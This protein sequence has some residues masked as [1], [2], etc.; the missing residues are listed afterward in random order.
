MH[1]FQASWQRF[2][3]LAT[4]FLISCLVHRIISC[5]KKWRKFTNQSKLIIL[6]LQSKVSINIMIS[7]AHLQPTISKDGNKNC[8]EFQK[9]IIKEKFP[10]DGKFLTFLNLIKTCHNTKRME[11]VLFLIHNRENC[12]WSWKNFFFSFSFFSF[13]LSFYS[14]LYLRSITTQFLK[15]G[16]R[17]R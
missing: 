13:F 8:K 5:E 17:R 10:M 6:N 7:M 12:L 14:D 4:T 11:K 3:L 9:L 2:I 1:N 16:T 15:L